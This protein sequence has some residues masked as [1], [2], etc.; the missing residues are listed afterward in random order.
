MG[1]MATAASDPIPGLMRAARGAYAQVIDD[2]V[3]AAGFD[4]IPRNGRFV[5]GAMSNLDASAADVIDAL[6]VSKQAASQVIDVLVLRGYLERAVNP[7]DRRRMTITLTDRGRTAG[8]IVHAGIEA[9]DAEL[10]AMISPAELAGLRAGLVALAQ[11]KRR[12][13]GDD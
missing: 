7:E 12:W 13:P 9:V 11:I 2:R 4:D 5:L 1:A 8:A 10:A 3:D 6:D